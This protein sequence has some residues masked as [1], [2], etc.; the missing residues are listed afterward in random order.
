MI[1]TNIDARGVARVTLNRPEKHNAF[2]DTMIAQLRSAFDALAENSSVKAV[3]LDSVGKAF[4]AGGDLDWM[5]RMVEYDY[6]HNL[7][8][9]Q[10]LA[11]M[12]AALHSLP[13]PTIARVQG[14][15]YGGAVGL[16]SCCDMAVASENA[17]FCLSEVKIG[18]IPATIG[19]Y[20]IRA[21]GERAARRYFTT[22]EVFSATEARRLGLV[23]ELVPP[24]GLDVAVE[25]LLASLLQ[26]SPAAVRAA[27]SLITDISDREITPGL[28][29]LTS[30]RIANIRISAEG[31]EG[32]SAFLN[33][34]EPTWRQSQKD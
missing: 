4:S 28:I 14:A 25:K 21:I 6:A 23:S 19:P 20:V 2:D 8:D 32:L 13:Q 22:A 5:K 18:L 3:L 7:K 12:L 17:T 26:N 34:R 33:R 16:V 1:E 10:A 31:Q 11:E 24:E 27:K 30:E 9:A 29:A 15:T